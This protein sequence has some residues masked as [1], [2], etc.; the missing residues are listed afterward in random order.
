LTPRQC[1]ILQKGPE[2]ILRKEP[3]VM[4]ADAIPYG[5]PS[6]PSASLL[7]TRIRN[8]SKVIGLLS[9]QS[10]AF[11]AYSKDDL[12]TLQTLADLCGG[13]LERIRTA[14]ALRETEARYRSIFENSIEGIAQVTPEG[15]FLTANPALAQMLGYNSPQ[16]LISSIT[17]IGRQL[18]VDPEWRKTLSEILME[19]GF[20]K[21]YEAEVYRKDGT[22]IWVAISSAVTRD[23]TGRILHFESII[24]DVTDRK[25][26]EAEIQKLAAFA[27]FNPNPI[28]EFN[29]DGKL[30]YFNESARLLA[31]SIGRGSLAAVLPTDAAHRVRECL[32]KG[33]TQPPFE[34]K[35]GDRTVSWSFFPIQEGRVVH[36]YAV[37]ITERLNLESQLRHVQKLESIGQLAAGV[38]HDFNNLLTI[39]QG[40]TSLLQ[41]GDPAKV[42]SG[43]ALAQVSKAAQRGAELTR[44]LL[45]F[46]RRQ[47]MRPVQL[48]LNDVVK[49]VGELLRRVLREDVMLACNYGGALPII[50]ADPGMM[51]QIVMNLAVNARDAMPQGGTLTLATQMA[52]IDVHHVSTHPEAMADR[53][54]CLTVSDT[55]IGMDAAVLGRIFEPFFT[56]KEVGKGTG[57]GLATVYGVVKQHQGWIEVASEVGR[58]S[59]FKVFLPASSK[60]VTRPSG[61]R[62]T[63]TGFEGRGETI[64][65]VED[66]PALRALA[67]R[68]LEA[69]GY[70]VL[71]SASGVEAISLWEEHAL[72]IDLLLTDMV[73]PGGVN[74]RELALKLKEQDRGIK[75]VY[76]SGYSPE[77]IA[78]GLDLIEGVNF[79]AK[80]YRPGALAKIVHGCL[81]G[82]E[83]TAG[84]PANV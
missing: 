13:A 74:G 50:E 20:L 67:R 2:L 82:E 38:A 9:I 69:Y 24:E 65:V 57:L 81:N 5:D 8:A 70:R 28:L 14:E 58:G 60:P 47:P 66:E 68:V 72:Q 36:C 73:M 31:E 78:E 83:S 79:L 53:F 61:E 63:R 30:V 15:R 17:D 56:T 23:E 55:G 19:R 37:D 4:P 39:I 34:T 22:T 62:P 35:I 32:Q 84:V 77:A 48:D 51:E 80:P 46:S 1:R 27:R 41:T 3:L 43:E 25:R 45:T 10:Y 18:Y 12:D 76:T 11:D 44:Q 6:R 21:R 26:A 52:E 40:Y 7:L 75:V 64:L 71:E 33:K 54:A 29:A 42:D 59:S 49:N 16:E